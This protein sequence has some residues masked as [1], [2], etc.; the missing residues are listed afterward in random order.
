MSFESAQLLVMGP[1]LAVLGAGMIVLMLEAF[2]SG[3]QRDYLSWLT[4]LGVLCAGALCAA[5]WGDSA[6]PRTAFGDLLVVDRLSLFLDFVFLIAAGL[7]AMVVQPFMREHRFEFGEMYALLLFATAGMMIL[8]SANDLVT[9]FIGVE[10]LS[11]AVYVLTGSWRRSSK[12]SEGAMKYFITGAFATG[13][14]L[15]GIALIYG[16][17]G[18]TSLRIIN[19]SL[20]AFGQPLFIIGML[21]VIAAFGFK[22]AAVPFHMWAPDAYEG[23]P[24]PVTG[25]MAAAVKTA[26]FGALYRV[27]TAGFGR[28]EME[29]GGSGWADVLYVLSI[30]TMT[31]GNLAAL[32]QDNIKRLLAY[33]SIAH[34]GYL[35]IGVTAASTVGES[36]RGPLLYYLLAYS[37]TTLGAF[38]VVSWLGSRGDE[39][40]LLDDWAGLAA[41]HPVAA[42]AMTIFMLSLGGVPPTAG[43]FAKF[44]LFRAALEKPGLLPLVIVAVL[45]SVISVYYYLRVVTAMYFREVGRE[46]QPLRS[47]MLNAALLIAVA[48]TLLIGVFPGWFL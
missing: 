14:L 43:F 26:A 1:F 35:L 25:Y 13:I 33:S 37:F 45:N 29:F 42:L 31:L 6:T 23:A 24:T 46:P 18:S 8:A 21:L 11:L 12:S 41:R 32:K 47:A 15:Y 39:R 20:H 48:A 4:L 38:A 36:A 7:T 40:L 22:I 27:F 44:Y 17:T 28:T 16:M 10:T 19:Q 2:G 3:R 9:V 34:A 5:Q 30:L